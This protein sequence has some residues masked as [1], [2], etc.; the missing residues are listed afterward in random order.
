MKSKLE[1][2]MKRIQMKTRKPFR[3]KLENPFM[4]INNVKKSKQIK[5]WKAHVH[6]MNIKSQI[7][8]G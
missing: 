1:K 6:K 8:I 2:R 5:E 7:I 4:E 3:N